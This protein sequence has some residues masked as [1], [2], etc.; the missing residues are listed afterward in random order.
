MAPRYPE[1]QDKEPF[2]SVLA[3]DLREFFRAVTL[4]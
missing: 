1:W 4:R 2:K 3:G